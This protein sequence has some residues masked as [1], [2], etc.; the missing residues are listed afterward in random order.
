MPVVGIILPICCLQSCWWL[1]V[2]TKPQSSYIFSGHQHSNLTQLWLRREQSEKIC[3][4][5][6]DTKCYSGNPAPAPAGP[7]GVPS[8]NMGVEDMLTHIRRSKLTE[9]RPVKPILS[10]RHQPQHD[11]TDSVCLFG[12]DSGRIKWIQPSGEPLSGIA[13][14]IT[15]VY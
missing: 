1:I 14:H 10:S 4:Q 9:G 12:E 5:L 6:Q 13:C 3:Q 8:L 7:V 11:S 2:N 15:A